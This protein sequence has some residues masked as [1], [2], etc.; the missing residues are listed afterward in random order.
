ME[1]SV[2][3]ESIRKAAENIKPY[4]KHTPLL[5]SE[6]LD[7]ILGCEVY[8]KPEGLQVTGS[9][10]CRGAVNK[11]LSLTDGQRA[12]GVVAA[13]SGN[14]AQGTAYAGKALGIKT[15]VVVPE[16]VTKAKLEGCINYG[17]A[18]VKCGLT[19]SERYKKADAL[20]AEFGYIPVPAFD[21]P[22][23]ISGQG[24]I[25]LEI[26]EDINDISAIVVPVGGGGLISGIAVAAKGINPNVRVIGVETAAIPRYSTSLGKGE[27]VEVPNHDTC[28]D[29][30]KSNKPGILNFEIIKNYVDEIVTVSESNIMSAFEMVVMKAKLL[31]ET[32]SCVGVAAVLEKKI[33]FNH[34]EKV[35]FLLSGGNVDK[36]VLHNYL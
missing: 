18:V 26:L 3:L 17:A 7:D 35:V 9:F 6:G 21:D 15:T 8:F 32:S 16:N 23:I 11:V 10:K 25:G 28:A 4:V 24:T 14:H 34:D 33:K 27:A 36:G 2:S 5:R 20:S 19:S 31:A 30:L 12:K 22:Y 1:N 29:A 13:S